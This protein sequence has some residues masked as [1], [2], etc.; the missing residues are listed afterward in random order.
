MND[1][2]KIAEWPPFAPRIPS[3][4]ISLVGPD[5]DLFLKGRRAEIEGFG[6]GAFA[7]YRRIIEDQKNR[8]LDEIIRVA[9]R[10]GASAD[11]IARLE[12]AKVETQF[13]KAVE[14]V[15]NAIPRVLYIKGH[16]PFTLLHDPLSE[17]LHTASDDV[18]L[19]AA[20]D[21]RLLLVAF[22]ERLTEAMKE[23]KELDEALTRL[24]NRQK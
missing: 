18:C 21:I 1:V 4:V 12:A 23:Q 20:S 11:S 15:K 22:A 3:K 6:V 17:D 24:L 2:Q 9:R 7:Y 14:S 16:N 13:S 19:R 5:R 10:I 8:F